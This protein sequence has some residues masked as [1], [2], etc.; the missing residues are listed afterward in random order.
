[1]FVPEDRPQDYMYSRI[2]PTANFNRNAGFSSAVVGEGRD[3]SSTVQRD[4]LFSFNE[5]IY[6]NKW[7]EWSLGRENFSF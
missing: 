5:S 3:I 1:M 2:R 6:G 4:T 7:S